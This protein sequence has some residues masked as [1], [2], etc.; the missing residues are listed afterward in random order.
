MNNI[1]IELCAEDR[2]RL[3]KVIGL[4]AVLAETA[5]KV[6]KT[7]PKS[8]QEE[9]KAESRAITQAEQEETPVAEIEPQEVK[10]E[11]PAEP[12]P[13]PVPQPAPDVS[14]EELQ[15]LVVRLATNGKKLEARDI[16]F[17]YAKSVTAVPAE[18]RGEL[19][20]RLQKLE[21]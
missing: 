18:K 17:E 15:G 16:V 7:A 10:A 21:D 1:S 12:T 9:P 11:A 4:L 20:A 14:L 6:P 5:V 19:Y 8:T 13:Q 3:D 2:A